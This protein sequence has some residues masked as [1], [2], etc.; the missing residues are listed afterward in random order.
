MAPT[1]PSAP[2]PTTSYP[3]DS[4]PGKGL[5]IAG[6][7]TAFVF[8]ILGL[9]LSIIAF[10]QSK[11]AGLKNGLALAGIIIGAVFTLF[12]IIA[13]AAGII[14]FT[15]LSQKCEELGPGVHMDGSTTITCGA[16]GEA[17][18]DSESSIRSY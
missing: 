16:N 5:G 1:D 13:T 18:I 9:I 17:S 7:V 2:V 15:Q 14:A 3:S 6:F 11:K 10:V 12:A 4:Y 8:P